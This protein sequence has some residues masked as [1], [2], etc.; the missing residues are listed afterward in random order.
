MGRE[1]EGVGR[2]EQDETRQGRAELKCRGKPFS[3]CVEVTDDSHSSCPLCP[4]SAARWMEAC[5]PHTSVC[6]QQSSRRQC[7][8]A[9]ED[10]NNG[11]TLS[12]HDPAPSN[13]LRRCQLCKNAFSGLSEPMRPFTYHLHA[14]LWV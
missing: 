9:S 14:T 3:F 1:G 5:V 6:S 10:M 8:R 11:L 12:H 13:S 7:A 4:R 2:E